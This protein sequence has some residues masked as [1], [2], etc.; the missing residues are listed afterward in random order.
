LSPDL[1]ALAVG[2]R[3]DARPKVSS[4]VQ[5]PQSPA[6]QKTRANRRFLGRFLG[7]TLAII[8]SRS[9]WQVGHL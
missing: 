9:G 4:E 3:S 8:D 5:A 2:A 6:A 7:K 1:A